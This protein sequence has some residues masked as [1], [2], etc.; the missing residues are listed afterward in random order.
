MAWI[1]LH[2]TLPDHPKI[3]ASCNALHIDKDMLVGKLCRLWTWCLNHR[4]DG[5]IADF[6]KQTVAEVMRLD[7]P[8]DL[9]AALCIIPNGYHGGLLDKVNGGFQIHDWDERVVRLLEKREKNRELTRERVARYREGKSRNSNDDVTR[10][11]NVTVTD[12]T[13]PTVPN[14]T[15]P[16]HTVPNP[17]VP[18]QTE[19]NQNAETKAASAADDRFDEF[20]T[21]YP[22]K[23]GK[24]AAFAAWKKAKVTADLHAK[25]LSAVALQKTSAQWQKN[26]GEFVPHPTTWLNQGRWDDEIKEP[27]DTRPPGKQHYN[28]FLDDLKERGVI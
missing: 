3:L 9:F 11:N 8:D 20:W 26:G 23:K 27:T 5:F 28:P 19:Q 13:H 24:K 1:E 16:N 21:A 18:N 4:E 12:V 25:I 10:Y 6:D 17:T 2:D 22:N 15:V 7:N 14:P